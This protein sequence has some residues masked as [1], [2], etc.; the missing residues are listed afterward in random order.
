MN[1]PGGTWWQSKRLLGRRAQ[2]GSSRVKER[3]RTALPRGS[4]LRVYSSRGSFRVVSGQLF[5]LRVLPGCPC[6]PHLRW[7]P[8]GRLLGGAKRGRSRPTSQNPL[9]WT[10]SW[11]RDGLACCTTF[12]SRTSCCET[13]Q[14]SGYPPVWARWEDFRQWCPDRITRH[15]SRTGLLKGRRNW[16]T[17][18]REVGLRGMLFFKDRRSQM[19]FVCW[20]KDWRGESYWCVEYWERKV[21]PNQYVWL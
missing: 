14:A 21:G 18:G 11:L 4:A 20:R 12:L 8:A 16:T 19:V 10:P 5:W 2:A 7:I 9:R 13:V 15:F 17:L 1:C 6:I 3:R